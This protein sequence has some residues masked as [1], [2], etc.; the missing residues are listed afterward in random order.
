MALIRAAGGSTSAE[1]G[2]SSEGVG[3]ELNVSEVVDPDGAGTFKVVT[4][5]LGCHEMMALS[6][7]CDPM[8]TAIDMPLGYAAQLGG[9][10]LE[11]A[12]EQEKDTQDQIEGCDPVAISAGLNSLTG[13]PLTQGWGAE[14]ADIER[15]VNRGEYGA[16]GNK[17]ESLIGTDPPDT[18]GY[19]RAEMILDDIRNC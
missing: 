14:L 1:I 10:L 13:Y 5:S 4:I 2:G 7:M 8:T 18:E 17:L 9:K 16:A 12:K 11:L 15:L 6:V 19:R 3:M